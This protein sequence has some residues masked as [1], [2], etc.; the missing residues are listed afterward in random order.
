M[1]INGLD[2]M[3]E[4][5]LEVGHHKSLYILGVGT[6]SGVFLHHKGLVRRFG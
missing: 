6:D 3:R 2:D 4:V 1:K 5:F